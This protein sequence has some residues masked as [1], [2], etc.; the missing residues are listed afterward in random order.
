MQFLSKME[1]KDVRRRI[2][3]EILALS[4]AL[5][6]EQSRQVVEQL[7]SL[8]EQSGARVV[9][10]FAPLADEVQIGDLASQ[11]SCRVALPRVGDMADGTPDME[12]F[13]YDKQSLAAGAYGIQEPQAGEVC[14]AAD[15]DVM[16][17]P[18]V[19]FTSAGDRLGRG[20]GYY[21]RY[22]AREGFRAQTIGVC[23]SCQLCDELPVE[24][25]DRRVDRVIS[26]E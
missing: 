13:Y 7:R 10:L 21:D 4:P 3:S 11:L 26:A 22:M 2:K 23:Y 15:I 1:K 19:A 16:V 24:E 12:F 14:S 5:Q 17:V 8:I 18:G 20:K 25:H 6:A 9:A